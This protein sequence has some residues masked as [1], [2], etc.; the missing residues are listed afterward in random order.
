MPFLETQNII[1]KVY[2]SEELNDIEHIPLKIR[3]SPC[4][5]N[6][7]KDDFK[8]KDTENRCKDLVGK[9]FEEGKEGDQLYD[10]IHQEKGERERGRARRLYADSR[11]LI[12]HLKSC[13][14][15]ESDRVKV[16][17]ENTFKNVK[18]LLNTPLQPTIGENNHKGH[19][20]TIYRIHKKYRRVP[21]SL[22]NEIREAL[23]IHVDGFDVPPPIVKFKDMKFPRSILI[24]LKDKGIRDPTHIQMQALPIALLG[25][26]IIGISSTGSGKTLVFVLPM[27]MKALEMEVRSKLIEGE[28]PFGLIICPSRELALQTHDIVSY[29]SKYIEKFDGPKLFSLAI[30]GGSSL[31]KQSYKLENGVHMVIATPGRLND[32]LMKK[33]LNLSQCK[34]LCFDEADR[35]VDL[36]FEDEI[37]S[38]LAGF[39]NP[40]QTLL[41]SATMPRKIQEFAKTALVDPIIVNVGRTGASNTNV[42]QYVELVTDEEKLPAILRCLQK[43]A[44][45]V[46]IFCENR[47]DVDVIHEYLLLKGVE[48]ASIH[49]GFSQED[50]KTA[51]EQFRDGKKDVLIGTDVAS[52][53]LDFPSV[54]HVINFD[55]PHVIEDYIHRIGRT[56]RQGNQGITTTFITEKVES[57]ILADLKIMLMEANQDIP[58][59]MDK[60]NVSGYNLK[61]TGGQRGCSFCGGLG[62]NISQC[63]KLENQMSKQL[64]G[65][66][67]QTSGNNN[68]HFSCQSEDL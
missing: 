35:L 43:T 32:L 46:L 38:V 59:F 25:R 44:P 26:D 45:P 48:V 58:K 20:E 31:S 40:R 11:C 33:M 60:I 68:D 15:D 9:P 27:I 12:D 30:I 14:N 29:F 13:K 57:T 36:G 41:F 24:A 52:K 2:Y 17:K 22:A 47:Q 10:K 42:I 4:K 21:E 65:K 23:F 53:G 1:K 55:M 49:G 61:E 7:F 66:D 37:R 64:T 8:N 50:R 67:G 3:R 54:Q 56:G 16:E 5:I 28:G 63:H 39:R 6:T 18:R 62:H 19:I 34:Y 51:I